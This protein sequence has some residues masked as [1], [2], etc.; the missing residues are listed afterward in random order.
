[1]DFR[2]INEQLEKFVE[3]TIDFYTENLEQPIKCDVVLNQYGNGTGKY[4]TGF[5]L[6]DTIAV[7]SLGTWN[8]DL[9]GYKIKEINEDNIIALHPRTG[10]EYKIGFDVEVNHKELRFRPYDKDAYKY[11][12]AFLD[13]DRRRGM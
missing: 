5:D 1:M 9:Y 11:W 6:G 3:S 8:S 2:K 10:N 13:L 12:F 7:R 4:I